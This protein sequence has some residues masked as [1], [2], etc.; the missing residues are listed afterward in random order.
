MNI[1]SLP[2]SVSDV[3][4]LSKIIDMARN[5]SQVSWTMMGDVYAR[6]GTVIRIRQTGTND[7]RY[8]ILEIQGTIVTFDM[9]V[10][11]AMN[12]YKEGYLR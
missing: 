4:A 2:L 7:I 6:H 12:L 10:L 9:P 11:T 8:G 3:Y 1:E 5:Q